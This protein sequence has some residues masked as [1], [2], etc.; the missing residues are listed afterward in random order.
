MLGLNPGSDG[1]DP[2]AGV[3]TILSTVLL[4]LLVVA[5]AVGVAV[6]VVSL[7]RQRAVSAAE[8]AALAAAARALEG[9]PD[10]CG[11]AERVARRMGTV[12]VSC[13][14]GSAD[15]RVEVRVEPAGL[16]FVGAVH[17]RARAGVVLT[18]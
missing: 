14:A 12:L 16:G 11:G 13:E 6:G 8:L 4:G 10:A 2:E 1:R 15:Y 7:T 3:A 5:L 9:D 17:A 18:G